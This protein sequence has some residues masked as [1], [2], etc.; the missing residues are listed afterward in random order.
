MT[1]AG[2]TVA[3][4]IRD[5]ADLERQMT[6]WLQAR[7]DRASELRLD[8]FAYPKGAGMSHETILF[9]AHW[10]E[11]G[12]ARSRGLVVRIKPT[13]HLVYPDDMFEQQYRIMAVLAQSGKVR[14]AEPLWLEHD[15]SLLGAPFFVMEKRHGKVAVSI[16]PYMREGWL[17]DT[18]PDARRAIWHNAVTELA[19]IQTVPLEDVAFLDPPGGPQGFAYEWD[20]WTRILGWI[21]QGRRFEFLERAYATLEATMPADR[22]P[23]IVWGDARIGNMM[24]GEDRQVAAVMDWE[25][26]SL[27]G[28]LHDLGWWFHHEYGQTVGAGI[29]R[30][31]GFGTRDET[32]AL[33]SEVCGKSTADIHW[34]EAFAAFKM[35]C[36]NVRTSE[37]GAAIS[38]GR[39]VVDNAST[40]RLAELLDIAPPAKAA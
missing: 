4:N 11:D 12:Q 39:D 40:R 25:Q 21:S 6:G 1:T 17:V 32:L 10:Q 14:V 38:R 35:S 24:I 7:L 3:P 29:P 22:S 33:W 36:L 20:R 13:T 2:E 9:D 16:P 23:G 8:N 28:P 30:L 27:G 26:P 31:E 34:H 18:A 37:L 5:L 15:P 19:R